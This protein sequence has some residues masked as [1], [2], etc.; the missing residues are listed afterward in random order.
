MSGC[1]MSNILPDSFKPLSLPSDLSATVTNH[2]CYKYTHFSLYIFL[3]DIPAYT[4][5][6]PQWCQRDKTTLYSNRSKEALDVGSPLSTV[7]F[8]HSNQ[9][10]TVRL[11]QSVVFATSGILFFMLKRA[12]KGLFSFI[13]QHTLRHQD[14]LMLALLSTGS[15]E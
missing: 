14:S 12:T 2:P 4:V 5:K 10:V 6:T 8:M 11:W 7:H 9:R 13:T 1:R 15:V 3:S